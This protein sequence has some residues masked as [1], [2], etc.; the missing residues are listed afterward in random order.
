MAESA[1]R[2]AF[3]DFELDRARL[4]LRRRDEVIPLEPTPFRLLLHLL[5]HRDRVVPRRELLDEI[6]P[7]THVGD[8]SLT[9]A[10]RLI[11]RAL[12]DSANEALWIETRPRSGYRFVGVVRESGAFDAPRAGAEERG[13]EIDW[14]ARDDTSGT[15]PS[16]E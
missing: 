2:Y 9:T 3:G 4:E 11:R 7:D 8:E 12:G 1:A 5:A 15:S 13:E 10:I 16:D 14:W 6:W